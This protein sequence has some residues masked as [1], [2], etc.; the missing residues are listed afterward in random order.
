MKDM[1]EKI[2]HGDHFDY[3]RHYDGVVD[4]DFGEMCPI[5]SVFQPSDIVIEASQLIKPSAD[6]YMAELSPPVTSLKLARPPTLMIS[7]LL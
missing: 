7:S 4:L 5:L 1:P 6:I 3:L 2:S